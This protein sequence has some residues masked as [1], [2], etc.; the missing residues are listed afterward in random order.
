ME[1]SPSIL[2]TGVAPRAKAV[3]NATMQTVVLSL[4][5]NM[6]LSTPCAS[7]VIVVATVTPPSLV[8]ATNNFA[9]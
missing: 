9:L 2:E 3:A 4:V 8:P 5:R 1:V 7:E 6:V